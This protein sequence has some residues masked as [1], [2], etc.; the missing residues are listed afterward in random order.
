M[1]ST[2]IG[3]FLCVV[4]V[5]SDLIYVD[6]A[7]VDLGYFGFTDLVYVDLGANGNVQTSYRHIRV[8]H[9]SNAQN[10]VGR[11]RGEGFLCKL[12][13]SIQMAP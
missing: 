11:V 4:F 7:S 8:L 3:K 5:R 6:L 9:S 2:R 1:V 12:K 10:C 13:L